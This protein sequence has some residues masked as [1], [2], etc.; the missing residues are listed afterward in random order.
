MGSYKNT[1]QFTP[2]PVLL[3][4][5]SSIVVAFSISTGGILVPAQSLGVYVEG[6]WCFSGNK[7]SGG[8]YVS[9][10]IRP[11]LPGADAPA[12]GSSSN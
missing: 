9:Y 11:C 4:M 6:N 10:H 1:V 8:I 12:R 2:G 7:T 5:D 3:F